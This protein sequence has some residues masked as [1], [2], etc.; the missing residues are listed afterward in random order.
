M[1]LSVNSSTGWMM[2]GPPDDV[3]VR[4]MDNHLPALLRPVRPVAALHL[5]QQGSFAEGENSLDSHFDHSPDRTHGLVRHGN[6]AA[7]VQMI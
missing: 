2:A 7:E 6:T 3:R 4:P 5:A 1:E